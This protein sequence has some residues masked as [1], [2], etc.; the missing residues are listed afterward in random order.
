[1]GALTEAVVF[2]K[3][4]NVVKEMFFAEFEAVLDDVVGILDFAGDEVRAAFVQIDDSLK[5]LG[6]VFFSISF[7]TRGRVAGNWNIPLRHLLDHASFGPDLGAGPIKVACR[8][9]CPVDWYRRQL[10]DPDMSSGGTFQRM[11]AAAERNRLGIISELGG[12]SAPQSGVAD[13]FKPAAG[14]QPQVTATNTLANTSLHQKTA[15]VPQVQPAPD[16]NNSRLG[17]VFNR[18]YRAKLI[19]LRSAEKLNLLTQAEAYQSQLERQGEELTVQLR[20][21]EGVIKAQKEHLAELNKR[22]K[23]VDAE[24]ASQKRLVRQKSEEIEALMER[25]GRDHKQQV[26][27]LRAE[28]AENLERQL[29]DQAIKLAEPL[30]ARE[31]ELYLRA[32]EIVE[33][34]RELS[35]L[36]EQNRGLMLSGDDKLLQTMS[37]KGVVF[38]A[39]HPGVEHLVISQEEMPGYLNDPLAYVA[40]R[41]DVP[42]GQYHEWLAHYRLPICRHRDSNGQYCGEPIPKIM[43]PRLFRPGESDRC[44]DH[45]DSLR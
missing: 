21:R 3:D 28:H 11:I 29:K 44:H 8:S 10:W 30:H 17:P 39:Y 31:R 42:D 19:A 41:C 26:A 45:S 16:A 34:R 7:D 40:S 2:F 4:D 13:F 1:M 14:A 35:V 37:E 24:L 25:G 18:R 23:E 27:V 9:A 33:L 22:F 12:R 15:S 32:K 36:R 43:R 38:V 6:A 20:E 5:I